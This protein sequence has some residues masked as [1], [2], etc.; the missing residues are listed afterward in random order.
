VRRPFRPL[1]AMTGTPTFD[2]FVRGRQSGKRPYRQ[3]TLGGG[4]DPVP[5]YGEF[6]RYFKAS[7]VADYE[8]IATATWSTGTTGGTDSW[9]C[10]YAHL[11]TPNCQTNGIDE[12]M[13]PI[14]YE[15]DAPASNGGTFDWLNK[16][17]FGQVYL[18]A[19][20]DG[21]YG[22]SRFTG[23]IGIDSFSSSYDQYAQYSTQVMGIHDKLLQT[24]SHA[25]FQSD[26][27][28]HSD[29]QFLS[30]LPIHPYGATHAASTWLESTLEAIQP[31]YQRL[32]NSYVSVTPYRV[33]HYVNASASGALHSTSTAWQHVDSVALNDG[34]YFDV[35]WRI[36]YTPRPNLPA[37]PGR[38]CPYLPTTKASSG[39]RRFVYQYT[40]AN[41]GKGRS[42][43][44]F[45]R[46]RNLDYSPEFSYQEQ[47]YQIT[48]NGH[49]GWTL[50]LGSNTAILKT[51]TGVTAAIGG[52][53]ITW[54]VDNTH[55][56]YQWVR[57][58][59]LKWD[60]EIPT[61]TIT[62]GTSMLEA[63]A[64][65]DGAHFLGVQY[66]PSDSSDYRESVAQ[67]DYGTINVGPAG[68]FTQDG[69]TTFDL[70][71]WSATVGTPLAF[72]TL[73]GLYSNTAANAL[74]P[75]FPDPAIPTSV[76]VTR[77]SQ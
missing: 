16:T 65:D 2:Q 77:V 38:T 34:Y 30:L 5:F 44:P 75:A 41:R 17:G 36:Q 22:F 74:L 68:T 23:R 18:P 12:I 55:P 58:I 40:S 35:W 53:Q 72:Q 14:R 61:L 64:I 19:S 57:Q 15:I 4:V 27:M 9:N 54:T 25:V 47:T 37:T 73:R 45:V 10:I 8:S 13:N 11:T 31:T 56:T 29:P 71:P 42:W 24:N 62:A 26:R 67:T 60:Q 69:T 21:R 76:T 51:G 63:M 49:T 48:I 50:H 7:S 6:Y 46:L 39:T 59:V 1:T 32:G 70:I 28:T 52:G 43:I 3:L 20:H 33:Q 66:S